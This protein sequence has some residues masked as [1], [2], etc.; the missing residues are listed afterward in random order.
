MK[1]EDGKRFGYAFIAGGD[2]NGGPDRVDSNGDVE[3][4]P[5]ILPLAFALE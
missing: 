2:E 5:S 1:Q 4:R 3:R